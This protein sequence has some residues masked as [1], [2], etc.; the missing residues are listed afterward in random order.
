MQFL[1]V[2]V[3]GW[4]LRGC[5]PETSVT[6]AGVWDLRGSRLELETFAGLGPSHVTL[7]EQAQTR[8]IYRNRSEAASAGVGLRQ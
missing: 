2:Q 7:Q 8:D 6:W 4:H 3:Q 5:V 1:L